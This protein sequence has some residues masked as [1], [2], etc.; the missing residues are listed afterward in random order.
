[1]TILNCP[2]YLLALAATAA[3]VLVVASPATAGVLPQPV[4]QILYRCSSDNGQDLCLI[5][6]GGSG[7]VQ[8]TDDST[9]DVEPE[10]SP[11]GREIAWRHDIT[12]I[13][14]MDTEG[15][16]QRHVTV[17][18]NAAFNNPSWSPGGDR[19]VM[20]CNDPDNLTTDGLCFINANGGGFGFYP[21]DD[22][23]V[24]GVEWSPN[25]ENVLF[26]VE[27]Q[28][29]NEDIFVL[30]LD[31]GN[32]DNITETV[33]DWEHP[34]WSPHGT[35]IA[36]IGS[37][38]QEDGVSLTGLYVIDPD[39]SNRER[40]FTPDSGAAGATN[41]AW[42]PDGSKI[43][44]FCWHS[45]PGADELCVVDAND[46]DL[47]D[48]VSVPNNG[49]LFDIA[50]EPNWALVGGVQQGDVDCSLAVNSVDALK[51]LRHVAGLSVSQT[52]PCPDVATDEA[53]PWGDVDCTGAV[54]SVDALKVLRYV[55]ALSVAQTEP[56]L[57][58]GV[59]VLLP[60]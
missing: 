60:G 48:V 42:S 30:N 36:F 37:P 40:L 4:E 59:V 3:A 44:F 49:Y 2:L 25:G 51:L 5:G 29:V 24:G 20:G 22:L 19:L 39:G 26:T 53:S 9:G 46:G 33:G 43:A 13:W 47:I 17:D 15:G 58:M 14:V 52:E 7:F 27:T 55:A 10:L 8:L 38:I 41:P 21:L 23:D 35:K 32:Y 50:M 6:P 18:Y 56:C 11:T 12:E 57:D 16:N 45:E 31:T 34:T 54:N 28:S 1:M